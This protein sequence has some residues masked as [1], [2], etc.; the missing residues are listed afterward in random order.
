MFYWGEKHANGKPKCE[1]HIF[2]CYNFSR[3]GTSVNSK[4]L[5]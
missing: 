3:N 2:P 1:N 4:G 5:L